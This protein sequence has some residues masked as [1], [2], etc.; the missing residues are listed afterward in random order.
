MTLFGFANL[1]VYRN[2]LGVV[3]QFIL[4]LEFF[5]GGF[6]FPLFYD[7]ILKIR[8]RIRHEKYKLSMYSKLSLNIVIILTIITSVLTFIF[9]YIDQIP[10]S[11]IIASNYDNNHVLN[12]IYSPWGQ[13][14]VPNK[15]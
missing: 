6:G 7:V 13:N 3:I 5:I 9:A 15:N 10:S 12:S 2:G 4:A 1:A 8:M 14:P 11:I